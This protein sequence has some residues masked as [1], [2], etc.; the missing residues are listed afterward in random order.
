MEIKNEEGQR[1]GR[2][3][4]EHHDQRFAPAEEKQNQNR[5]AE[6]GDAHVQ[7]QLVALL[8]GGVAVVARDGDFDIARQERAAE[9]VHF[10]EHIINHIDGVGSRPFGYT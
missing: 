8:C 7:E 3:D 2:G 1:E 10:G 4:R 6:D 5:D 9:F